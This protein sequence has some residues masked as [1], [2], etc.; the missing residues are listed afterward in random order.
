V[1][2]ENPTLLPPTSECWHS[3]PAAWL[4]DG[5]CCRQRDGDRITGAT[6]RLS[7]AGEQSVL[8]TEHG[9]EAQSRA[10]YHHEAPVPWGYVHILPPPCMEAAESSPEPQIS[11]VYRWEVTKQLAISMFSLRHIS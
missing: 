6:Q 9:A 4:T 3:M 5:S 2:V 8:L 10:M 1:C 11:A 7:D